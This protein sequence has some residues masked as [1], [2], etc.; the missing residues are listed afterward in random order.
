MRASHRRSTGGLLGEPLNRSTSRRDVLSS[1]NTNST[2]GMLW[3][4]LT[5]TVRRESGVSE[6]PT[7]PGISP[8]EAKDGLEQALFEIRRIIAGQDAMLERVLVCLLA[9]GHLL[10]EGVPGL[11]KTLTIKTTAGVLGARLPACSSHRDRVRYPGGEGP[12]R[13][14][15][16]LRSAT[17]TWRPLHPQ[18]WETVVTPCDCCGQVV[19]K[20]LWVVEVAGEESAASADR[21][22]EELYR[23]YVVSRKER[24][25]GDRDHRHRGAHCRVPRAARGADAR[26]ARAP[27]SRR[28]RFSRA[29]S[30]R[31]SRPGSRSTSARRRGRTSTDVDGNDYVDLIMGFGPNSLG[32]SPPVVVDAVRA[33]LAR[34]TS[35]A[36]ATPL[37]VELAQTISRLVPEH[38]ADALRRHRHRGDDDGAPHRAC[39]HRAVAHRPLRGSLPRPARRT[40]SS[41]SRTSPAPST[42]R[43]RSRTAPGSRRASST[44]SSSSPGT[45]STSSRQILRDVGGELAAII[46]EPVPF[47]NLGGEEPDHEFMR[48]FRELTREHG[49]AARLRR[50]DHRL[51]ARPRRRR[52]ALR[53]RSRPALLRQ[54]GRR[55]LPDRRLR[56]PA[57]RDGGG[58]HAATGRSARRGDDLPVGHLLGRAAG[59]GRRARDAAA[60]SSR[61]TR[62][63]SP[64]RARRRSAP[65][66]RELV[67]RR[68]AWT[69][70]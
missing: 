62:S 30:A 27:A 20:Q 22:C 56:R 21:A 44:T 54:D 8:T 15:A 63:P 65:G 16:W 46:L 18:V 59:D 32:H 34:G 6:Q 50:G 10:I 26:L 4:R 38:G 12:A 52:R 66:W 39:L 37:E 13:L 14:R 33:V 45:T 55:R 53:L 58:R 35:L 47:S 25:D 68:S 7:E 51:P 24:A 9:Q 36:I 28:S 29:A 48:A 43:R 49:V 69:P 5:D 19:A 67:R 1:L 60:S 42:G 57:R 40:R 2:S 11:A 31:T 61:R 3:Y 41:A 70:R 17:G 23:D 64:T